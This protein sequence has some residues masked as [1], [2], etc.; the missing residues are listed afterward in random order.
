MDITKMK[1][2]VA[3]AI[4]GAFVGAVSLTGLAP[5]AYAADKGSACD[6]IKNEKRQAS[7]MEREAKKAARAAERAAKK[8]A[9]DAE[10]AAKKAA[11]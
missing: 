5:A 11:K 3:L 9:R 6:K 1:K 2:L 8:A 4:A 7:C 10:K